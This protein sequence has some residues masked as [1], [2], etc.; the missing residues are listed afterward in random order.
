MGNFCLSIHAIVCDIALLDSESSKICPGNKS[1]PTGGRS[2][3]VGQVQASARQGGSSGIPRLRK[4]EAQLR[5]RSWLAK[6]RRWHRRRCPYPAPHQG[7]GAL[8]V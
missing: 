4:F 5:D 8:S 2:G 6:A 3:T 7:F 1:V